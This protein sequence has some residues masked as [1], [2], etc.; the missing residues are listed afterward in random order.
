MRVGTYRYAKLRRP[1]ECPNVASVCRVK[2]VTNGT[3][4]QYRDDVGGFHYGR[5]LGRVT[6]D[7]DRRVVDEMALV[8][9]TAGRMM[10]EGFIAHVLPANVIDIADGGMS[11]FVKWWLFSGCAD[12]NTVALLEVKNLLRGRILWRLLDRRGELRKNWLDLVRR[13]EG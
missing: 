10:T 8:V 12:G 5:V 3:M 2:E 7:P 4:L 9:L 1:V 6:R 11:T 13:R